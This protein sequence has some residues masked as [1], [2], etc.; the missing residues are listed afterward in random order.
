MREWLRLKRVQW[1]S[2]GEIA[3]FLREEPKLFMA[4]AT[5]L[6]CGYRVNPN[7]HAF[8]DDNTHSA[9]IAFNLTQG[10]LWP[11]RVEDQRL[12]SCRWPWWCRIRIKWAFD[13]WANRARIS[14]HEVL[15]AS[16]KREQN[17]RQ[18]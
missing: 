18:Q 4:D 11:F 3:R 12:I 1:W 17:K 9:A 16:M 13:E 15:V 14:K 7:G 10:W 8:N 2:A 5:K 6:Y